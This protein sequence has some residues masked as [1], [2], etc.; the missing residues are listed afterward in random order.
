[1]DK[2]SREKLQ[3]QLKIKK[4]EL[5]ARLERITNNVRQGLASDSEE[6][7]K[8]LEDSEVVDALGNEAREELGKIST[9]F[10]R[11]D[12]GIYGTCSAC[13]GPIGEA[14]LRAYPYAIE[15]IDCAELDEEIRAH[16]R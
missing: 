5:V 10:D 13:D 7:A 16:A 3:T 11:L 8:Q 9:V 12:K 6:R 2:A 4:G 15:C 14:R 1:M